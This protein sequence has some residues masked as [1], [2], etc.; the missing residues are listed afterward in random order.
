[1]TITTLII[2]YYLLLYVTMRIPLKMGK[3]KL[4]PQAKFNNKAKEIVIIQNID[5]DYIEKNF[6]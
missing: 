4:I 2:D 6:K 3:L 5:A 1:M